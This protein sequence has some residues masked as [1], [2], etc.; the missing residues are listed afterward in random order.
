MGGIRPRRGEVYV[1]VI[2]P[3]DDATS[4]ALFVSPDGVAF[5]SSTAEFR[6]W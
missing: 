6:T 4:R 2:N 3:R 1:V 5:W